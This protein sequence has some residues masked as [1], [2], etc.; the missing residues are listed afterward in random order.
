[1]STDDPD[2][3]RDATPAQRLILIGCA[4]AAVAVF[5][6]LATLLIAF[7]LRSL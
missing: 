6:A 1:M 2:P 7:A 4:F 3:F 5:V